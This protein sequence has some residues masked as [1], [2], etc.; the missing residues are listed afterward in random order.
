MTSWNKGTMKR[1]KRGTGGGNHD[2]T[3]LDRFRWVWY[4]LWTTELNSWRL[5]LSLFNEA[6]VLFIDFL[7]F[8]SVTHN[9]HVASMRWSWH[10][11][12]PWHTQL[13]KK[14]HIY[15]YP[16]SFLHTNLSHTQTVCHFCDTL[17][18]PVAGRKACCLRGSQKMPRWFH[19]LCPLD[20]SS[21]LSG[22][23]DEFCVMKFGTQPVSLRL[24]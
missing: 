8:L 16:S 5:N 12:P 3:A 9:Y 24:S 6:N 13:T 10:S 1:E 20:N 19:M 7:P 21:P 18:E 14:T 22:D 23:G 2:Q 11:A 17:S 15:P 4:S